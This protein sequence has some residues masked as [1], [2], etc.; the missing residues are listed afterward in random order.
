MANKSELK[1]IRSSHNKA[2]KQVDKLHDMRRK[3]NDILMDLDDHLANMDDMLYELE[4]QG[5]GL[6]PEIFEPKLPAKSLVAKKPLKKGIKKVGRPKPAVSVDPKRYPE[7]T[8][9]LS[10]KTV[11]ELRAEAKQLGISGV[12]RLHKDELE[13]QIRVTKSLRARTSL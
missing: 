2:V 9:H 10:G 8:I 4:M 7:G 12:S 13:N 1:Q 11:K 6:K 5:K 3:L